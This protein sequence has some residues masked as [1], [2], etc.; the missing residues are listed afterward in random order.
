MREVE[1]LGSLKVGAFAYEII[2]DATFTRHDNKM[3]AT[4]NNSLSIYVDPELPKG[5]VESIVLHELLHAMMYT[6]GISQIMSDNEEF[7]EE[8]LV[9]TLTNIL[10]NV[11]KDNPDYFSFKVPF[12]EKKEGDDL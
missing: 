1:F 6:S 12:L 4:D 11:L 10:Y 2:D 3:G 8:Y 9:F 5:K 7:T